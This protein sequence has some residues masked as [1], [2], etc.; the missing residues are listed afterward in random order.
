MKQ[1]G[2]ERKKNAGNPSQKKNPP[3]RHRKGWNIKIRQNRIEKEKKIR[4]H[5]GN[6]TASKRYFKI[7]FFF[8]PI[9]IVVFRVPSYCIYPLCLPSFFFPRVG[10]ISQE[11]TDRDYITRN[12][13]TLRFSGTIRGE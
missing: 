5:I 2:K 4:N 6:E 10:S 12:C 3:S 11:P 9:P 1:K 8:F 7:P 13:T